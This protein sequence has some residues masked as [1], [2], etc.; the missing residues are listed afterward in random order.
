MTGDVVWRSP[1]NEVV[2]FQHVQKFSPPLPMV[3]IAPLIPNTTYVL[4]V[5]AVFSVG[6]GAVSSLTVVS[7]VPVGGKDQLDVPVQAS[8]HAHF[9]ISHQRG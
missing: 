7:S 3:S 8:F 6:A 4:S 9:L 1:S 5:R 2:T